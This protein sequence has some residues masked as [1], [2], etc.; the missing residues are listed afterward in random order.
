MTQRNTIPWT[1]PAWAVWSGA[2][3]V[4]MVPL[5]AMQW[6]PGVRW[7]GSD[8]LA[9]GGLLGVSGGAWE[10]ARRWAR[11]PKQKWRAAAGIAGLLLLAWGTLATQ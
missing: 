6:T 1:Q 10:V 7:T 8:F 11:T 9:M 2:A 3:G 4:L 5:M